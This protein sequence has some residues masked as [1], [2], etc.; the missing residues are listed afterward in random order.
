MLRKKLA[1]KV[2]VI[3]GISLGCGLAAMMAISIWQQTTSTMTLQLKNTRNL[4]AIFIRDID[5]Y[6]MKGDSK[7]VN[8]Y[9]RENKEK[10]LF[11]DL[12]IY[13]EHGKESEAKD[14]AVQPAI[15]KALELGKTIEFKSEENGVKALNLAIPFENEQRCKQCHDAAP[16]F[17][18]GMLLKT[19]IQ[20]GYDSAKETSITLFLTSVLFFFVLLGTI[21]LFL[22][23][24]IIKHILAFSKKVDELSSGAGDL[25][26][27]IQVSSDDE[28]G[29][30]AVGINKLISKIHD[31]M[32]QIAQNAVALSSSADQ[33]LSTSQKMTAGIDDAVSQTDTVATASEEMAATSSNIATNC[34]AAAEESD[35]ANDSATAGAEVVSRT[36]DVMA[37]IAD[38]V[39]ESATTI[40]SLGSRSDQIGEIVGTIEDIADQTNLLALNAAIEAARAGEQ[41][42]GFAVVADEV[43][44]LA[45]RTTKATH[46][47]GKMIKAI[48]NETK[49]AVATME[50]GVKEVEA[51]TEEAASSG[52]AIFEII[53][54]I[55]AVVTQ[56]NQIATAAE[57]Q[58]A[59]TSEISCNIQRVTTVVQGAADGAQ[60]TATAANQLADLAHDLKRLVGLFKLS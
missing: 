32:S 1:F 23:A 14:G 38:K 34:T 60:E 54:Q 2:L 21:F 47:I 24:A 36:I 43:R 49:S 50:E 16:K 22:R 12:K 18:G 52:E 58:T 44:A 40:E 28:I 9:I 13:D 4:A 35:K 31:I 51:G 25:T 39:R 15:A 27:V 33:L 53:E 19:S 5:D 6:M 46:E 56:V 11:L 57:Q 45:E 10:K 20:E 26:T 48:Q 30:L 8:K 7:E 3:L 59:T 42:R 37:R 41:G 55:R 17:L 29:H